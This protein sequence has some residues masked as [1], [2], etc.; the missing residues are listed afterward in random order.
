MERESDDIGGRE[1]LETDSSQV[2]GG[3]ALPRNDRR[4]EGKDFAII[5]MILI[6]RHYN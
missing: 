2:T 4:Q 6:L 1:E 3:V 5:I